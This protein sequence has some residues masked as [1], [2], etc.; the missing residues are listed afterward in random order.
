MEIITFEQ[1][2]NKYI[3][4]IGTVARDEYEL[5]FAVEIIGNKVSQIRR[6]RKLKLHQLAKLAKVQAKEVYMLEAGKSNVKLATMQKIC[7]ALGATIKIELD[8]DSKVG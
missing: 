6:T 1:F 2:K 7:T 8:I 4:E 3:G 5:E